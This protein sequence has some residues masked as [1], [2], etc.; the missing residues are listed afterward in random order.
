MNRLRV[1]KTTPAVS[2]AIVCLLAAAALRWPFRSQT[3]FSWDSANF[4]LALERIDIAAHRPHPPGYLAYVWIARGLVGLGADVNTAFV[5]WNIVATAGILFVVVRFATAVN[6]EIDHPRM[7][8][9][10]GLV[11]LTGPLCWFYGEITEIYISEL[12][13]SLS[14]AFVAWQAHRGSTRA[15]YGCIV[16]LG[17]ASLFKPSAAVLVT[18]LVAFVWWQQA[19]SLRWRSAS[20]FAA[21]TLVVAGIF[22]VT[23][24]NLVGI[25]LAQF[26]DATGPSRIIGGSTPPWRAFNRN[27]RD[28]LLSMSAAVGLVNFAVLSWWAVSSRRLPPGLDRRFVL[29][30]ALPQTTLLLAVHI[31]RPGYVLPLV[32]LAAIVI[33]FQ[34]SRLKPVAASAA[35][36]GACLVNVGHFV[37]LAPW[38]LEAMGGARL[39]A[40]KTVIQRVLSDLEPLTWPTRVTIRRADEGVHTLRT[41]SARTCPS[42]SQIVLVSS[43]TVDWRRAMWYLPDG[44]VIRL[45]PDDRTVLG[46]ATQREAALEP[47]GGW[48]SDCPVLWLTSA[49]GAPD[50]L[51]D[52]Q[53]VGSGLGWLTAPA[54]VETKG[55]RI[56]LL[57]NRATT[58][59]SP[60]EVKQPAGN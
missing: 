29:A 14:V 24:P 1:G 26:R 21:V 58:V 32:P 25:V 31:G 2:T 40:Q 6:N 42:G 17:L 27:V 59:A 52:A 9:C 36:A 46:A 37:W 55:G 11:V 19:P 35:I 28:T 48:R 16:S 57:P 60:R 34:Y 45:A 22:L 4:A 54:T 41:V 12:L 13:V 3:L 39:Y 18:P 38:S 50:E 53:A 47:A 7:G 8:L 49:Q 43:G 56:H 5:I 15:M 51:R 23:E 20:L 44:I 10:A 33:A 30:W